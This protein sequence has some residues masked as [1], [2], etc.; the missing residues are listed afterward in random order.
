MQ[1]TQFVTGSTSIVTASA[2]ASSLGVVSGVPVTFLVMNY[3]DLLL[4]EG[5]NVTK[6]T[7]GSQVV[8]GN[9][10]YFLGLKKKKIVEL[11]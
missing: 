4:N 8:Y 1:S 3:V 9:I 7:D 10:L 2:T 11:K 6:T 5:F